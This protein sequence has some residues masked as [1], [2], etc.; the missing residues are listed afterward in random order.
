MKKKV[1]T[2]SVCERNRACMCMF[3][4]EQDLILDLHPDGITNFDAL[5]ACE[6][7]Q[8]VVGNW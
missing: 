5:R 6:S 8:G 2:G 1:G 4:N 7:L 3:E